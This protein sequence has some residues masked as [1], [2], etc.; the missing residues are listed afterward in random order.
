MTFVHPSPVRFGSMASVYGRDPDGN[1]IEIAEIPEGENLY[2][3]GG[4]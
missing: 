1:P 2:L 3:D 4:A